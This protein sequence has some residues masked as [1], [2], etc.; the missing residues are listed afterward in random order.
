MEDDE[1]SKN[2]IHANLSKI[3]IGGGDILIRRTGAVPK[4]IQAMATTIREKID[5]DYH[6]EAQEEKYVPVYNHYKQLDFER[7][8]EEAYEDEEF[9]RSTPTYHHGESS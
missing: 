2:N 4:S 6:Q 3:D 1:E 9:E 7:R 5:I 8:I